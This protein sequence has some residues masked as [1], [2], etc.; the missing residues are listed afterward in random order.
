MCFFFHIYFTVNLKITTLGSRSSSLWHKQYNTSLL[1]HRDSWILPSAVIAEL[2]NNSVSLDML[3]SRHTGKENTACTPQKRKANFPRIIFKPLTI[4]VPGVILILLLFSF[5]QHAAIVLS[6][7]SFYCMTLFLYQP[8]LKDPNDN[9]TELSW[10]S[11]R[12][13]ILKMSLH[14]VII[15]NS[16]FQFR[17]EISTTAVAFACKYKQTQWW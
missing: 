11:M 13:I 17:N 16:S 10:V 8:L 6:S 9:L 4:V 14:F 3:F 7:P 15:S 2:L 12:F 5:N 1:I